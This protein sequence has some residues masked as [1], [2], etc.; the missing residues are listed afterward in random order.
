M[1]RG[2]FRGGENALENR[3]VASGTTITAWKRTMR[4]KSFVAVSRYN[5]HFAEYSQFLWER[6]GLF[7][8]L[9]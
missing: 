8:R 1:I 5:R 3:L 9:F 2:P 6:N 7:F 4:R